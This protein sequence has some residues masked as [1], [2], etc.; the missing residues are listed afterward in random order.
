MHA[1][2]VRETLVIQTETLRRITVACA[3][4][5]ADWLSIELHHWHLPPISKN[6]TGSYNKIA[7]HKITTRGE[8]VKPHSAHQIENPGVARRTGTYPI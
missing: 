4:G 8:F 5:G 3:K 7:D 1:F 2:G 6:P